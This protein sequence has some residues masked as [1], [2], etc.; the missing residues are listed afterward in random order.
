MSARLIAL[1]KTPADTA[2]FDAY[3][4]DNHAPLAKMLPGLQTYTL[5]RCG[6]S[7][8]YYL[9]A[10]LTFASLREMQA[11]LG[12]PVGIATVADLG[13]FA[14]AGVDVLTLEDETV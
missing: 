14:Q 3:Y 5:G 4:S 1:Y 11:A 10:T 12:S 2:A 9:V 13:K 6:P 8:P 7:D